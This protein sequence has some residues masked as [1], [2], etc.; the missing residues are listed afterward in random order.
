MS[1]EA[2]D[3]ENRLPAP[4]RR[5]VCSKPFVIGLAAILVYTLCGFFLVPF[6]VVRLVPKMARDHLHRVAAVGK[7]RCNPYV[8]TF[9]ANDIKLTEPDGS[10]IIELERLFVDFELSSLLR[11]AWTFKAIHLDGP[12]I[13]LV[14][15]P[16]GVL[17]LARLAPEPSGPTQATKAKLP[18]LICSDVRL[19]KGQIDLEDRRQSP[20]AAVTLSPIAID[21]KDISTL[22]DRR[23]LYGLKAGLGDAGTLTW[24]GNLQLQPLRSNG[25]MRFEGIRLATL[26]EFAR[27]RLRIHPPA[28]RLDLQTAYQLDL[29]APSPQLTLEE[30]RFD[31]SDLALQLPDEDTPFLRLAKIGLSGARFDLAARSLTVGRLE[32]SKG[33]AALSVD[34]GGTLNLLHIVPPAPVKD[35]SAAA[36]ADQHDPAA[37]DSRPWEIR[38][39]AIDAGD[40]ALSYANS[41]LTPGI[42]AGFK[43]LHVSAGLQ[44]KI[45]DPLPAVVVDGIRIEIDSLWAS[46]LGLERP[47]GQLDRLTIEDG[48]IDSANQTATIGRVGL[49]GGKLDLVRQADGQINWVFRPAADH[50]TGAVGEDKKSWQMAAKNVELSNFAVSISDQTVKPQGALLELNPVNATLSDV[51]GRSPTDFA[52]D[53]AVRQGG[54]IA[55][56]GRLDPARMAVEC[57]VAVSGLRLTPFQDYLEPIADVEL[58]SGSFSSK[59]TFRYAPDATASKVAYDGSFDVSDLKLTPPGAKQPLLAWKHLATSKVELRLEPNRLSIDELKLSQPEG[60]FIIAENGD[61]NV[62]QV[63]KNRKTQG[64]S[65]A[66]AKGDGAPF[67][68]QVRRLQIDGGDILYGDMSLTP[69]FATRIHELSGVVSG[70][71]SKKGSRAQVDLNGRVDEFGTAKIKGEINLSDPKAYTDIA[72]DFKNVEMP[73][74]T[75]YTGKFAGRKIDSGKLSLDLRYKI[76]QGRLLGQNQIIVD[77]LKLGELVK[78]PGA[79]NLPLDLAVALLEDKDGVINVGLPVE[80]DLENPQFSFGQLV[81]KAIV[82]LI[83]KIATAPFRALAA[84]LGLEGKNLEYVAFDPGKEA[85]PP[86]EAEKLMQLAQAMEKRPQLNLAVQGGYNPDTD[87]AALRDLSLRRE[88]AARLGMT[89]APEQDPGP[90]DYG[91]PET[92]E[93]LEAMFQE[94]FG[95]KA[96]KGDEAQQQAPAAG[97]EQEEKTQD[98]GE[99]AKGLF[100]QMAAT[101]PLAETSLTELAGARAKAVVELM[102]GK[103]GLAPQRLS[104]REPTA[105]KGDAVPSAKLE[106]TAGPKSS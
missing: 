88:L 94:R 101:Q 26:W 32:V 15:N 89:L 40:I 49:A 82:N 9:E 90:V 60:E 28:G 103:G 46:H 98:P 73:H 75:P 24:S 2:P 11:W 68:V 105:V 58:R 12:R 33:A 39:D 67:P 31:L 61:L 84:L 71:S 44:A 35:V 27:D 77:R 99:W 37:Q 78:S 7:V 41:S 64:P 51:D 55:M 62:V 56:D 23:G 65:A 93:A 6:L 1:S 25:Q 10:P 57:Q 104:I 5:V 21:L 96:L 74:L 72:V 81:G 69:Q 100:A 92:V 3:S 18:R 80:G 86:P 34:D 63:L 4:L 54:K 83:T 8:F 42:E 87:A 76:D 102:T 66:A 43:N 59:G 79:V 38:I 70:A 16:D 52:L 19:T 13:H 53:I 14:V 97:K 30:S 20:T 17:N 45:G 22:P 29:S 85:V 91:N 106:L 47:I 48:R 36:A 50:P 95:A